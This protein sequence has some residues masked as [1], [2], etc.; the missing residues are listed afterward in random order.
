MVL[1]KRQKEMIQE[2]ERHSP[3]FLTADHFVDKFHVSMRTIQSDIKKVREHL[4]ASSYAE[5][6]S[7]ASKGSQLII[8]DYTAF[9]VNIHQKEA[10]S[11]S[12][13]SD[14]VRKLCVLLLNQKRPIHRQKLLDQLFIA[15]STLN[16]DLKEADKLL[17]NYH[18]SVE[19]KRNFGILIRGNEYDKRKCLLKLGHLD[20]HQE[21][22]NMGTEE[23]FRQDI[24]MVPFPYFRNPFPESD[25]S[26]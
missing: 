25:R 11:E 22:S 20:I 2:F 8:K 24:E 15:S 21:Q 3:S 1:N 26:Y 12:N 17:S 7:V 6:I 5:I 23:M 4:A 10:A 18:L 9:Q 14:R 16:T 19:R 13:Q